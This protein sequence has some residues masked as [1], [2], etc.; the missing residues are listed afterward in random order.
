[1]REK[2]SPVFLGIML[3]LLTLVYAEF[4]A[5]TFGI[6]EENIKDALYQEAL[7]HTADVTVKGHDKETDLH[8]VVFK[9]R[10][11]AKKAASKAWGYLKRAHVHGEG[12]GAIVLVLSLLIAHSLLKKKFKKIISVIVGFGGFAYPLC[13][14]YTGTYMVDKGKEA[15]KADVQILAL[16]SVTLYLAGLLLVFSLLLLRYFSREIPPVPFF[17]EKES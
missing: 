6:Y 4:L 1:M 16:S 10:E 5:S 7:E 9:D 2:Y 15:A 13:W 12:M 17:F 3:G 11:E 14:F 8:E